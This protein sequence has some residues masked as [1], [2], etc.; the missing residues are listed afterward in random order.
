LTVFDS[1]YHIGNWI[2]YHDDFVT[3]GIWPWLAN[4]RKQMRHS[5]KSRI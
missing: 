3:P 5:P 2:G 4:S 1:S